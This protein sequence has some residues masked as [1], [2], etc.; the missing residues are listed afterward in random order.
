MATDIDF[1][2]LER[3]GFPEGDEPRPV[4][5]DSGYWTPWYVA[6][7]ELKRLRAER[8]RDDVAFELLVKEASL[9]RAEHDALQ[10]KATRF[11]LDAAGIE[12]RERE[13]VELVEL[14]AER[15]ALRV[16]LL[17]ICDRYADYRAVG[18]VPAPHQYQKLVQAI[19]KASAALRGSTLDKL[20][21]GD[22]KAGLYELGAAL[23]GGEKQTT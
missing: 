17:N 6:T 22:E 14:R 1:V 13:A 3:Y 23:R 9:L 20:V 19:E 15:N 10:D 11:D 4:R 12:S 7:E 5:C 8:E 16:L 2:S 18:A 21:A